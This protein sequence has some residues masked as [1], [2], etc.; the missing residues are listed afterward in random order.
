MVTVP[1][2]EE[3]AFMLPS[4][5]EWKIYSKIL[6]RIKAYQPCIVIY[7]SKEKA[8]SLKQRRKA[9]GNNGLMPI[10]SLSIQCFD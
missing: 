4:D 5:R 3:N 9:K 8:D 2:T 7:R 1:P 10:S 6:G